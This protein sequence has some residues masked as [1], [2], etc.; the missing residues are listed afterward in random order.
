VSDPVQRLLGYEQ[1]RQLA[2]RY[3][4][5][6][7]SRDLDAL[8]SL[9]VPDVAVGARRGRQALRE[10]FG[11]WLS[12]MGISVLGVTTHV[13]DFVDDE[14]ASGWCYT[15]AQM[16]EGERWV[17]Q[18]VLYRDDYVR[19]DGSWYFARSRGHHLWYGAPAGVDPLSL[20]PADWPARGIGLG[21]APA[22][23][24]P[25]WERFWKSAG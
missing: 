20:A 11:D 23:A 8:V 25:S 3:A 4:L 2:H 18:A 21:D 6:V 24:F 10:L 15:H 22:A 12:R 13:I 17:T 1:I 16:Q 5:A 9:Y 14:Q 19:L 7:D